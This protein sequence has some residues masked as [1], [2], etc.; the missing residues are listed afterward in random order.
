MQITTSR[1]NDLLELRVSGRL[2]AEWADQLKQAIQCALRDGSHSVLL[3]FVEVQYV[4]S[5]G[6]SV[7]VDAHRRF[8]EIRGF[9][10]VGGLSG[11]VEEVIRLTGLS[12]LLVC[13][14]DTVRQSHAHALS[15][16]HMPAGVKSTAHADYEVYDLEVTEPF[17]WQAIGDPAAFDRGRID[18]ATATPWSLTE[19]DFAIGVGAFSGGSTASGIHH[20]ELL[21]AAGAVAIQTTSGAGRPDY[22]ML[23]GGF[24]PRPNLLYGVRCSGLPRWFMRFDQEDRERPIPLTALMRDALEQSESSAALVLLLAETTG[25][26]GAALR[27]APTDPATSGSR[28][29]HPGIRD[30]LTF[31]PEPAF[32]ESLALVVG[33][34]LRDLA[35]PADSPLRTFVRPLAEGDDLLGHFHAAVFP[36]RPFKKRLLEW[37]TVI[38]SLFESGQLQS[39]L[40]LLNDDRPITGAGDSHFLRG[41]AWV[42]PLSTEQGIAQ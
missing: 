5:A 35:T 11:P 40:H 29:D 15:T 26:V 36:F 32:A 2:D 33:V 39:V 19:Q 3:D 18:P 24:A 25:L 14:L 21:A 34:V 16:L 1:N 31:T 9:F 12:K 23:Q 4:S 7:L 13:D 10:G 6:L 27:Q 30:W 38:P 20:G 37:T 42:G 28:F 22:Q 41:A 17:Q 8:Q